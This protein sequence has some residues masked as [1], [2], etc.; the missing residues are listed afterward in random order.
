MNVVVSDR[1]MAE[2]GLFTARARVRLKVRDR[3]SHGFELQ[4]RNRYTRAEM[5]KELEYP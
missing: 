2:Y 5:R 4:I 1:S 3:D